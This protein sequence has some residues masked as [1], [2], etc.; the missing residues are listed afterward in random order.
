MLFQC[1]V[2][3]LY[4]VPVCAFDYPWMLWTNNYFFN[5]FEGNAK[6]V[7]FKEI[8]SLKITKFTL[9]V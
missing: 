6:Y 2:R 9:A 7:N 3:W 8:I 1:R 4:F 5:V